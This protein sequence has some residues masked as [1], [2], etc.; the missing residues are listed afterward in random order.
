MLINYLIGKTKFEKPLDDADR[1]ILRRVERMTPPQ[2]I[3]TDWMMHSPKHGKSWGDKWRAGTASFS[4][5]HHLFLPRAAQTL[6]VFW[7]KACAVDGGRL[8]NMLLFWLDSQLVNLSIQNRYRPHVSFP[9]NPLSGVYY[10][11]SLIS[12]AD[13]LR[14]YRNKLKRIV[15]GFVQWA[16]HKPNVA[17]TTGDCASIPIPDHSIDYVFTDPPF[18][19]N[20][21]YAELNFVVEA[22]HKCF[23]NMKPEAI[24]SSHQKKGLSEYQHIMRLCFTE[25]F[26]VLKPGRW[27]T[28]VFHNSRNSVWTAIQEGLQFAGFVVADVRVLDKK[29]GS[30]N[31]VVAVG[32]VKQDL[33]ISAYKPN[34]G[35][36][37]RFKLEAGTEDGVWDFVRTHLKQLPL[38]VSNDGQAE[39]VAER[40]NYLLFDRMVAFHVQRGV[41]VPLSAAE[42][43]AGLEQRFPPRDGMYFL[44]DQAAGYDKKRMKVKEVLQLQLFVSDEAS[45][46]QWL[47][48]QFT[49]KPQ[50]FQEIHPQFL[51]E[52]GGWQKHE[53][54][55]ELSELLKENLLPY[56][57]MGEVPSQI[58]SYLSSNHKELRNLAK[59]DPALKAKG[60][61]RWYVPDPNK[62][63]DLEKLRERALMH[64]FE[65]YREA[66]QKR[67]K[68]F[69]LE[70]VRAGF[71]RAWQERDYGTIIAVA[72]KIPDNILQ[73]DPKLL[74]WYDQAITRSGEEV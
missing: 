19:D 74:M 68:V 49:K 13:P 50:T 7:R 30:F 25:Y 2:E 22:F 15:S 46:I 62:A 73:E 29:Q 5:V 54:T 69:R 28:V 27:M 65:E 66:K 52:I 43:Y 58:H 4:H 21:A 70:A 48:Q 57:G 9:Y 10:I 53:K 24:V 41:T 34:G 33:V 37:E 72:R 51:K 60:K 6:A 56:D 35:L 71:K 11:S 67:L 64:E 45:A 59:D 3:P 44:P 47:K 36:E 39:V 1:T 12:E 38:F 63:G 55:L 20:L 31:Q 32:S 18:G 42:F 26:R 14:A 23:T 17:T 61:D 40:Q 16:D 8:K